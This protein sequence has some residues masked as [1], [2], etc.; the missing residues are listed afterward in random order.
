MSACTY[1]VTAVKTFQ[2]DIDLY[3]MTV[4]LSYHKDCDMT[5]KTFKDQL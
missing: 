1:F 4:I 3:H 5:R 2:S